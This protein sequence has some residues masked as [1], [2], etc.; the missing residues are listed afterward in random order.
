M[1]QPL[2]KGIDV[3]DHRAQHVEAGRR[4]TVADLPHEVAH[5]VQHRGECPVL[6]LDDPDG[7][8]GGII[9][10]DAGCGIDRHQATR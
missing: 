6:V 4:A 2:G 8:H 9:L 10:R 5:A 7:L 3:V 1:M